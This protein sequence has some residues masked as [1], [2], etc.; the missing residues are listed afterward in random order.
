MGG[1]RE[2]L[3]KKQTVSGLSY[4]LHGSELWISTNTTMRL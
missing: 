2:R 1:E 3:K 4:L